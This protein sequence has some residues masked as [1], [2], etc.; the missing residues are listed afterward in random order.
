MTY[1]MWIII[2]II[3]IGLLFGLKDWFFFFTDI[4]FSM[5][6]KN[7]VLTILFFI[8]MFAYPLTKEYAPQLRNYVGLGLFVLIVGF[9]I[10]RFLHGFENEED[11]E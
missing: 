7:A 11:S 10:N 6:R 3:V 1:L 8:L 5:S 2:G 9:F 4:W